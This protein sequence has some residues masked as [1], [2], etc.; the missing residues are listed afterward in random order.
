M[1]QYEDGRFKI[2]ILTFILNVNG[3]TFQ[4]KGRDY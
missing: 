2:I 4:L 1:G 3:L